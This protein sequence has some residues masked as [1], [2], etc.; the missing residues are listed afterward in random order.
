MKSNVIKLSVEAIYHQLFQVLVVFFLVQSDKWGVKV[1][2]REKRFGYMV[3]SN[4][5]LAGS[6]LKNIASSTAK[7]SGVSQ[8]AVRLVRFNRSSNSVGQ[9]T[10]SSDPKSELARVHHSHF[11]TCP[12]S[13]T[14]VWLSGCGSFLRVYGRGRILPLWMHS[15]SESVGAWTVKHWASSIFNFIWFH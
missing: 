9:S 2:C 6:G 15:D 12:L 11:S 7:L 14:M 1:S 8:R 13:R 4:R 10:S 5:S 3:W